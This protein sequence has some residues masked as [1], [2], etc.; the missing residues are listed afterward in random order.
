MSSHSKS[1]CYSL[2]I[3]LF[4]WLDWRC[5]RIYQFSKNDIAF[6]PATLNST[7]P[8]LNRRIGHS[9]T[10]WDIDCWSAYSHS[11]PHSPIYALEMH[12]GPEWFWTGWRAPIHDDQC[13]IREGENLDQLSDSRSQ[14]TPLTS[15]LFRPQKC[16]ILLHCPNRSPGHQPSY[17]DV[18]KLLVQQWIHVSFTV[19]KFSNSSWK[20]LIWPAVY[21]MPAFQSNHNCIQPLR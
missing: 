7:R 12:I 14:A 4:V 3:Y 10:M 1:A 18:Q 21:L 13:Q 8:Q 6:G 2:F 17:W 16:W 5:L 19:H 11:S 20:N 9:F 15:S